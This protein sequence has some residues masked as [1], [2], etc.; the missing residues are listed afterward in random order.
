[1]IGIL[2]DYDWIGIPQ[3]AL[4]IRILERGHAEIEGADRKALGPAAMEMEY[5]RGSE[6]SG[7]AAMRVGMVKMESGIVASRVMTGP[8]P[9]IVDVR[10]IRM[11]RRMP[12]STVVFLMLFRSRRGGRFWS[13]VRRGRTVRRNILAML[14]TALV[15]VVFLAPFLGI[16]RDA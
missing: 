6:A 15:L 7:E 13:C 2:V 3:P 14:P 1:M 4:N 12:E 16:E 10:S 5:V 9:V 8:M 11:A